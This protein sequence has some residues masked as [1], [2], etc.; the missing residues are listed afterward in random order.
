MRYAIVSDIHA[1]LQAWK[2]VLL[3]IRS[4]R[5]DRI[6]CLGDTVGYGPDPARVLES[7]HAN[8]DHLVLGNHDAVLCGKMDAALFGEAPRKIIEWTRGQLTRDA[9]TF[10]RSFPLTLRAPG[11]RC[12]HGEFGEPASFEYIVDPED[13]VPSWNAVDEQLLFV[14]H[15][16][17][18]AIFLLG[19]S[20]TPHMVA[21]QDF[22]VEAQK[23]Y[24][25][26]VGS[27]GLPRDGETRAAYC[28]LDGDKH[29]VYW[30]RVPFDID[31]YRDS[32]SAAG[33]PTGPSYFLRH[34]PRKARPPL[35]ELLSFSPAKTRDQAARDTVAVAEIT[36]LRRRVTRWKLLVSL[37]AALFALAAATTAF[38]V[39]RHAHRSYCIAWPGTIPLRA[40]ALAVDHN[41]LPAIRAPSRPGRPIPGW[42][43][44]LGHR[45]KQQVWAAR[46]ENSG[47]ALHLSSTTARDELN[48]V[49]PRVSVTPGMKLCIEGAFRKGSDFTGNTALVVGLQKRVGK[50]IVYVDPFIVKPPSM[51]RRGGWLLAKQTF[52]VPADTMS[53]RFE[54]R[55]TFTGQLQIK[56]LCLVRKN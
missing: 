17:R 39:W 13:A 30:H 33:L 16:H 27:V 1:N 25:V 24:I 53:L 52:E 34:D 31:A 45:R 2:A 4:R 10:L 6:I 20:G 48:L 51:S 40:A 3:D 36:Q 5:I 7:I 43:I 42:N 56:D 15:T 11:F 14:G 29:A 32:L 54:V 23:R 50:R 12:A 18:P 38:A 26:N 19:S 37:L 28:V 55:S 8:V 22:V 46:M 41:I 47:I 44:Q 21:P 35:R 49:S 9:V